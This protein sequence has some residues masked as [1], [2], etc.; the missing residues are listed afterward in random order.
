MLTFNSKVIKGGDVN[1]PT[2]KGERIYMREFFKKDGLPKDIS[3]WQSTVDQM[4]VDVETD[5]PIYLM[6]DEKFVKAN[7]YH[8][9]PGI[10][11]D[12]Y[13]NPG[14]QSCHGSNN[15]NTHH[16]IPQ[17]GP[18]HSGHS[19]IKDI[20][21]HGTHGYGRHHGIHSSIENMIRHGHLEDNWETASFKTDEAIILASNVSASRG[22]EGI[23]Q[24]PIGDMGKCEHLDIRDMKEVIMDANKVYVGNVTFLHETTMVKQDCYRSLVRLNVPGFKV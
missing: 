18:Q 11:I 2:F 13:W 5:G 19:S 6:V 22:F 12:G 24:G 3:R 20:V 1:F 21:R 14:I 23:F 16:S 9:R 15:V 4:L 8:R 17:R 10:H 7:S